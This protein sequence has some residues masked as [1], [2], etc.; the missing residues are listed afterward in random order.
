VLPKMGGSSQFH[1]GSIKKVKEGKMNHQ[2]HKIFI[3]L[4]IRFIII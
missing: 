4:F 1:V 3:L 2:K